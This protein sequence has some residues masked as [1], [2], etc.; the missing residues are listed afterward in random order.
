MS[1][2][3]NSDTAVEAPP[4]KSGNP[5]DLWVTLTEVDPAHLEIGDEWIEVKLIGTNLK[6]SGL[7][8]F[9]ADGSD[10]AVQDPHISIEQ[11][12]KDDI[13]KTE[14][15]IV[16]KVHPSADPGCRNVIIATS[17]SELDASGACKAPDTCF[18]LSDGV[19]VGPTAD[20]EEP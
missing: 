1:E 20:N 9:M 19:T 18:V 2:K 10:P 5:Q 8:A 7:K 12:G 3:P 16:V 14:F 15:P 4:P 17:L 11:P 6:K 13:K